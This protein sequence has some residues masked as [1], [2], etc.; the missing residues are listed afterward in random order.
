MISM[1]NDVCA[2]AMKQQASR[3][4][5][6]HEEYGL[7]NKSKSYYLDMLARAHGHHSWKTFLNPA[8]QGV[9]QYCIKEMIG[10][11]LGFNSSPSHVEAAY[12]AMTR[13]L[14]EVF[15]IS[16]FVAAKITCFLN[17]QC[18][19][20]NFAV[21]RMVDI[22]LSDLN[23]ETEFNE[24]KQS[25]NDIGITPGI[26][27][28]SGSPGSGKSM[29]LRSIVHK[30]PSD[31][32]IL[33]A[34]IDSLEVRLADNIS[35]KDFKLSYRYDAPKEKMKL[36]LIEAITSDNDVVLFDFPDMYLDNYPELIRLINSEVSNGKSFVFFTQ[37][38][39][40]SI[41]NFVSNEKSIQGSLQSLFEMKWS[42]EG[43]FCH[44]VYRGDQSTQISRNKKSFSKLIHER[45]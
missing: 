22:A 4:K 23:L 40:K 11:E 7:P 45:H 1:I 37:R 44:S 17:S 29:L 10:I 33:V 21:I 19:T 27:F 3:L 31:K 8:K 2:K 18:E 12:G 32:K 35:F 13:R 14:S 9:G 20:R 25:G 43:L 36:D 24:M 42:K 30:L 15:S 28:V 34:G 38:E 39:I 16:I 41:E 6:S 5:K 26:S